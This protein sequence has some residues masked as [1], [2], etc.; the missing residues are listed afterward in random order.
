[1][2]NLAVLHRAAGRP[3]LAL[4]L[5]AEVRVTLEKT[6]PPHHEKLLAVRGN[7]ANVL[8]DLERHDEALAEYRELLALQEAAGVGPQNLAHTLLNLG[9]THVDRGAPADA[10]PVLERALTLSASGPDQEFTR[11][12]LELTLAR[13]LWDSRTDRPRARRLAQVTATTLRAAGPDA[14][15]VLADV[16]EVARRPRRPD[17]RLALA[18]EP[19]SRPRLRGCP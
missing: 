12:K 18:T 7:Q 3:D 5:N 1:M 8:R 19:G 2:A 10:I 13:A 11:A 4:A 6:L 16:R 17:R 9:T 15:E 14:A